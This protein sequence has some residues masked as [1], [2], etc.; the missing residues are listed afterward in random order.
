MKKIY[1][2]LVAMVVTSISF[3]QTEIFNAAGG[4]AYPS[5]GWSD[6]NNVAGEAIDK[7]SYYHIEAGSPSDVITTDIYDL[8]TY[9]SAQ[10]KFDI[11]SWGSGA[12][13]AVFTEISYNNGATYTETDTSPVTTTSYTTHTIN[14]ASVSTQVK[15]R[16]STAATSGRGIRFQ[17][18]ILEATGTNPMLTITAPTD[19]TV[20]TSGTTNVNIDILVQNFAVATAGLGDGHIHWTLETDGGGA[21]MQP[22][23]YDTNTE[24]IT[25]VDGSSYTVVMTLVD[26]SHNPIAPAVN[27][28]VNFSVAYPCD[29]QLTTITTTCDAQTAGVDTYTTTID[30][31]GG[32]SSTYTIDTAGNGVV[33]GNNPTSSTTGTITI[34]GVNEGTDFTVTVTGAPANSSCNIIRNITSPVCVPT[35]CQPVGSIIITEIMQNPSQNTDPNGE[36]F[37]VYNTTG[38]AIDI[39]G[40]V[41]KDDVTTSET[42]TITAS[43]SVPSMGYVVIG[44][45]AM[46]N[47]G[48]TLDYTYDNDI[49][50][51]NGT[52]GIIIEC[53]GTVID[54]V[55]WDNGSTFPDPSGISME[56]ST[57]AYTSDYNDN[58]ANWAQAVSAYGT[59]DLGTPG[60]VNDNSAPLGIADHKIE[61]FSIFPN[62]SSNGFINITTANN[63][64]KN[65][66]IF[67]MLGKKVIDKEV[68]SKLNISA[69]QAGIY[70]VKVT[71][72]NLSATKRLIVK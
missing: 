19:S 21:V 16:F 51:S 30:F 29:L 12:H 42:H 55:I 64:P 57:N 53:T 33:T 45:G 8:S 26:D 5:A 59:G 61:G 2:F 4:G 10:V 31:T 67:D 14:L 11:R 7:T 37:E 60:S 41:I 18:I 70:I 9:G 17:N 36:Y 46:P 25:V 32:N 56:L 28:T 71:E 49:S 47:G 62:P 13:N 6:A 35:V 39:Q 40:W 54:Q 66:Q 58:G 69:L 34:I 24:S 72:N 52:D 23:K 27:D 43:L 15:I 38:G 22:M 20:F 63:N 68:D 3:G 44:N 1:F 50:L 65:V 48:V